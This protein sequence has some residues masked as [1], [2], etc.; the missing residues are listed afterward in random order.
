MACKR[1]VVFVKE[2]VK[3]DDDTICREVKATIAFVVL[4]EPKKDTFGRSRGMFMR[5]GG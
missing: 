1:E 2:H 4:R 5:H 3:R